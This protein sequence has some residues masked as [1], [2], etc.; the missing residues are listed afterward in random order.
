M[1]ADCC[2]CFE[3]LVNDH[4]TPCCEQRIHRECLARCAGVCP[5]CR[6]CTPADTRQLP[7]PQSQNAL[8]TNGRHTYWDLMDLY[9]LYP[10]SCCLGEPAFGVPWHLRSS[11]DYIYTIPVQSAPPLHLVR[12]PID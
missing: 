6:A 9:A 1:E 5:L 11:I 10:S 2:V 4:L 3:E 12:F 8:F 7:N